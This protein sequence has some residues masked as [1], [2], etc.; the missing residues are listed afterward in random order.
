MNLKH[1]KAGPTPPEYSPGFGERWAREF[2]DEFK[3]RFREKIISLHCKRE[4]GHE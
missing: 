2:I 4:E 1:T 3:V